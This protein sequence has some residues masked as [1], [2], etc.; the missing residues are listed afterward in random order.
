MSHNV[1]FKFLHTNGSEVNP[2]EPPRELVRYDPWLGCSEDRMIESCVP[3]DR[4]PDCRLFEAGDLL[5]ESQLTG[6]SKIRLTE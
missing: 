1:K 5:M 4:V 3:V 2:S 6:C